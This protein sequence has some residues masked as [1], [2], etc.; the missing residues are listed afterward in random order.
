MSIRST[1]VLAAITTVT[2]WGAWEFK[3]AA[4]GGKLCQTEQLQRGEEDHSTGG[5]GPAA[6][7]VHLERAF[8]PSEENSRV[9]YSR[10]TSRLRRVLNLPGQPAT[11]GRGRWQ[12]S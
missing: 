5:W 11:G 4:L 6:Q 10:D 9:L 12:T 2:L 7:P 8:C 1:L 3:E